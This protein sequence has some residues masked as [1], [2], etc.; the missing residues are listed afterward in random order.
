LKR[1]G[2]I[3]LKL[4]LVVFFLLVG[5]LLYRLGQKALEAQVLFHTACLLWLVLN[6][7]FLSG[8]FAGPISRVGLRPATREARL[9]LGAGVLTL[10]A[11]LLTAHAWVLKGVAPPALFLL[12]PA[13]GAYTQA[14]AGACV[15][16]LLVWLSHAYL[17]Q[18]CPARDP[19]LFPTAVL[20]CGFG[21]VLIFRLAPDVAQVLGKP[22][23]ESWFWLQLRSVT[24]GIFVF[25]ASLWFFSPERIESL[26]RKRYISVLASVILISVTALIGVEVHGR[27]LAVNL[28][29]MQFQTVELVKVL[30]LMFMVGYLKAEGGFLEAGMGRFG[31]P[32]PRYLIPY[33]TMWGLTLLPIF[34]QKD[35]GPTA[36]IFALFLTMFYLGTGSG[37]SVLSGLALM[38]LAGVMAYQAG[39]P[40]MVKTRVDMWLD[41]FRYSQNLAEASWALAA[42]GWIGQ[43]PAMG[44]SQYIPVVQSDFNFAA[45]AEDWG[46]MGVVVIL[47]AF[48]ALVGRTLVLARRMPHPYQQMLMT[49]IGALWAIQT[50]II[51]GGNLGLLPLTGITLPFISFGGSSLVVNFMMLAVVVRLSGLSPAIVKK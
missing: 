3:L 36:L 33:L 27:K 21:L 20:L 9:L 38:T 25:V 8:L 43:G 4:L 37:V 2:T 51:V 14:A 17:N 41:P 47:G 16:I 46:L 44:F 7:V 22:G 18:R 40:S 24:V 28:G 31:L 26:A 15:Y 50:F 29:L 39:I 11:F 19:R 30:A 12:L 5:L 1:I 10:L 48:A 23:I 49:G 6:L 42:G 45:L 35:L 13:A 32:R 34:L